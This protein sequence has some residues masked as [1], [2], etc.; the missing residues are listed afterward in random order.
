MAFRWRRYVNI[1]V[2]HFYY[3]TFA[4]LAF[5]A[6]NT[7]AATSPLADSVEKSDRVAIRTLLKQR[8]DVNAAQPD[9]MP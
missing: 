8:T 6:L 4:T 3:S 7:T 9:G 1:A 5:W 2:N